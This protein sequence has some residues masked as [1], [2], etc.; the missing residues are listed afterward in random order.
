MTTF[1][2]W[3]SDD[4][5]ALLHT[6]NMLAYF[7]PLFGSFLADSYLGK[8]KTILYLSGLYCVGSICLAISAMPNVN[9]QLTLIGLL[10]LAIGTGGIKPNVS[11][12]GADQLV[13]VPH[14]LPLFF[15]MFYFAIID[16]SQIFFLPSIFPS[17]RFTAL[18]QPSL[19]FSRW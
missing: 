1:K 9:D 5:T 12:F 10:L 4:A 2:E 8:F 6:F 13:N 17:M 18:A 19:Q 11:S 16:H 7:M 15:S 14:F 3:D